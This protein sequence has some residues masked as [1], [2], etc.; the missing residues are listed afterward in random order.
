M[1]APAVA[2]AYQKAAAA[3]GVLLDT[4][5][6]RERFREALQLYSVAAFQTTQGV[7]DS[8][9]TD[10]ETEYRRWQAIVDHVL[11]P[12]EDKR[13]QVFQTLWAHFAKVENWRL[14]DDILP[15]L[16]TLSQAGFRLGLASNF[17]ARLRPIAAQLLGDFELQL[18][19]SSEIGW[20]KPAEQFYSQVT[21]RLNLAPEQIL[22]I[23]D[24]WENDV[25]APRRFGWQAWFLNRDGQHTASPEASF[26]DLQTAAHRLVHGSQTQ[27]A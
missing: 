10:E 19:I 5:L 1:P 3:H 25:A 12:P 27:R 22:L 20:V 6:V 21:R 17:D 14:F 8:F 2:A 24:D 9:R 11:D 16:K 26:P 7:A 18:F 13:Q 15:G 23:G 4:A